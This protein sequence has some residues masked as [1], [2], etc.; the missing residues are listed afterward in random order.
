MIEQWFP[1]KQSREDTMDKKDEFVRNMHAQ[2]ER[3]SDEIAALATKSTQAATAM[4][5]EYNKQIEIL[6]EK[7]AA[8]RDKLA[9]LNL[10]SDGAWEDMKAGIEVAWDAVGKAIDSAKSRFK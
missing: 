7:Q 1:R 6:K 10:A 9:Q 3:W 2:M 4:Q 8:A 5:A